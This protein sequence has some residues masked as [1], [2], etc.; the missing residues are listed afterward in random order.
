MKILDDFRIMSQTFRE[1]QYDPTIANA[2]SYL[3]NL[4]WAWRDHSRILRALQKRDSL[5]ASWGMALHI[6]RARK[7]IIKLYEHL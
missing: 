6:K 2:Q 7:R 4:A 1:K 5:T 3:A